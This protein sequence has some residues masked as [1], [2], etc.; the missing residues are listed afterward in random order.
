MCARV[1]DPFVAPVGAQHLDGFVHALAPVVEGLFQRVVLG[2]L[3]S[4]PHAEPHA[5]AG[6]RVERRHLLGH[7]DRL[8][9]REH[10]HLG[11][12]T[13][14]GGGRSHEAQGHERFHDRHLGRIDGRLARLG[15][16]SHDDVV[17]HV[18]LVVPDL[19][20]ALR[21]PHDAGAAFPVRDTWKFD[22]QLH[23][24]SPASL[25]G[26]RERLRGTADMVYNAAR[27]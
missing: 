16:K 19:L 27:D 1:V 13:D 20:D 24:R 12:E 9:L 8:A 11:A 5:P 14:T 2:L 23:G 18:E 21:E 25:D 4:D 6:Q 15:G 7:E 17:E 22:S 3:P 10:E 26:F